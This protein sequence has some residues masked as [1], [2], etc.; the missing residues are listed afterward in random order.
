MESIGTRV[1]RERETQGISR[2]EFARRTG[3]GYSTIAELERG[4][5]ATSTKIRLLAE[6]LGVSIRWLETGK[7]PKTDEEAKP[8]QPER[9]DTEK[10]ID[11]METV[12]AAIIQS[13]RQIPTRTKAR[14]VAALYADEQA[15]A[16]ASGQAVQAALSSLLSSLS[17]EET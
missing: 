9:L 3:I 5:M 12:E 15:S 13:G 2:T 8:S 10:L 11:L 17:L 6:A 14:I 1:K 16:A 7:G 4:G